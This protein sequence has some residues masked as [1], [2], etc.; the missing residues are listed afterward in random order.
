M[1]LN[2]RMSWLPH[3]SPRLPRLKKQKLSM[4][5]RALRWISPSATPKNGK[6][7]SAILMKASP[8]KNLSTSRTPQKK[9][10]KTSQLKPTILSRSGATQQSALQ[11]NL[12]I[13]IRNSLSR[14]RRWV[15]TLVACTRQSTRQSLKMLTP[16]PKH[17]LTMT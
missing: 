12:S 11:T 1:I 15:S 17:R 13:W 16:K 4:S 9:L 2:S 5:F 8:R 6:I 7:C 10:K 14:P 3:Q